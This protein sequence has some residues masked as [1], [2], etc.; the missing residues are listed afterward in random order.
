MRRHYP[1]A[2]R[3]TAEPRSPRVPAHNSA[4]PP[5]RAAAATT[6]EPEGPV[7]EKTVFTPRGPMLLQLH[8]NHIGIDPP[9][10]LSEV[11]AW[12]WAT[13]ACFRETV[14]WK[15]EHDHVKKQ[16]SHQQLQ[17]DEAVRN[18]TMVIQ[19]TLQRDAN[20]APIGVVE[21]RELRPPREGELVAKKLSNTVLG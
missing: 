14:F 5:E 10:G 12:V 6:D 4:D 3:S 20:G 16:L 1:Q 21:V 2:W 9:A 7:F 8:G 13:E 11:D 17:M 19:R 15:H 18:S